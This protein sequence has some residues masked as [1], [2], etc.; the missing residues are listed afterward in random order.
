MCKINVGSSIKNQQD[1]QNL[2][3]AT[4]NRQEK[5]YRIE[6]ILRLVQRYMVGSPLDIQRNKLYSII[7]DNLDI[8]YIRNR[9]KCRNGFYTPQP[10]KRKNV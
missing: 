5:E 7:L 4:I 9:V 3:I 6:H 8:L 10:L 1:V 2:I